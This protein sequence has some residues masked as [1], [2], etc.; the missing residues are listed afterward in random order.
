MC[1]Y[2]GEL[3]V[4]DLQGMKLRAHID[5]SLVDFLGQTTKSV[6]MWERQAEVEHVT[7]AV[8]RSG[9]APAAGYRL[10]PETEQSAF[11]H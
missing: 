6:N 8:P 11:T 5:Q 4:S 9:F 1:F 10:G 3:C 2:T 7:G